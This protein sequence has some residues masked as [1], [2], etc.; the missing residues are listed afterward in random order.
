MK[1][2][3]R[4]IEMAEKKAKDELRKKREDMLSPY[5][6]EAAVMPL[7]EMS[8]EGFNQLYESLKAGH[9]KRL[10]DQ[11][12]AERDKKEAEERLAKENEAFK[13]YIDRV[14][15][16]TNL[17]AI[18][19][20]RDISLVNKLSGFVSVMPDELRAM[21]EETFENCL[22]VFEQAKKDN[23]EVLLA[24]KKKQEKERIANEAKLMKERQEK[25]ALQKAENERIEKEAQ[26]KRYEVNAKRRAER[27]PDKIK[28]Q[29]AID[30]I[31]Q[32]KDTISKIKLTTAEA[33]KILTDAD[34]LLGKTVAF[35][36]KGLKSLED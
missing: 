20:T 10:D 5:T 30:L 14:A 29:S 8:E 13:L 31:N 25:H 23:D 1:A 32:T 11:A 9:Q 19:S 26:A 17:G 24:E 36:E 35:T 7:A 18:V 16:L 15:K 21:N 22:Y 6:T 12:K 4:F 27:A 34:Q 2:S 33:K 28:V 3:A